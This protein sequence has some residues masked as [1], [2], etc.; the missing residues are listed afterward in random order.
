M[1]T[2]FERFQ[3]L[4]GEE[5]TVGVSSL[6]LTDYMSSEYS[7]ADG[8]GASE[9]EWKGAQSRAG[10]G[11][12]SLEVRQEMWRSVWVCRKFSSPIIPWKS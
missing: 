8:G 1:R 11:E 9:G 10:L 3:S 7:C 2:A 4:Y 5:H 12:G 6:V